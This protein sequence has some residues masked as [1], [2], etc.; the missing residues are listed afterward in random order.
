MAKFLQ[1]TAESLKSPSAKFEKNFKEVIDD[2]CP[3]HFADSY[4]SH[5]VRI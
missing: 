4:E 1:Q 3:R 5:F 2:V